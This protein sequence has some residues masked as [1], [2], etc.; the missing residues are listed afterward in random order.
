MQLPDAALP[1]SLSWSQP[2]SHSYRFVAKVSDLDF[3]RRL[4]PLLIAWSEADLA[5]APDDAGFRE[6]PA[7]PNVRLLVPSDHGVF[8]GARSVHGVRCVCPSQAYVD[9][10]H[11]PERS[12]EFRESVRAVVMSRG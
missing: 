2:V 6:N 11:E 1:A 3:I 8:H 9:L 7:G 12:E 5:T 4:T 10:G